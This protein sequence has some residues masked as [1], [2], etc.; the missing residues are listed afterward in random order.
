MKKL[1]F[2]GAAAAILAG[3]SA[4]E[5][6]VPVMDAI[7]DKVQTF[8]AGD[9]IVKC[10]V[11]MGLDGIRSQPANSQFVNGGDLPLAEF[12][13]DAEHIYVN[14]IPAGVFDGVTYTEYRVMAKDADLNAERWS[15]SFSIQ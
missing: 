7:C 10:P 9:M 13:A 2:C 15:V 3:C 1:V 5:E 11:T 12:A 8:E 4:K 6:Q 14:V